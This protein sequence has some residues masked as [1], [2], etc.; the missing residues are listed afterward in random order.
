MSP[1]AET[2]TTTRCRRRCRVSTMRWATRFMASAS[3]DGRTAVL[4]HDQCHL[5]LISVGTCRYARIRVAHATTTILRPTRHRAGNDRHVG[6]GDMGRAGA[7]QDTGTHEARNC[8]APGQ[9][10]LGRQRAGASQAA[11]NVTSMTVPLSASARRTD[12]PIARASDSTIDIPRPEEPRPSRVREESP[13]TKRSKTRSRIS[14][15]M[16]GPSSAMRI[17]HHR[18]GRGVLSPLHHR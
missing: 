8:N 7:T 9:R 1:I 3:A 15:G 10:R 12:P 6:A 4:L 17:R 5:S 2:T 16:P 13:R 14:V 18:R 11:G